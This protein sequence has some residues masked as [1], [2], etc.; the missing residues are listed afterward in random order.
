MT[1]RLIRLPDGSTIQEV[2]KWST[3]P[4]QNTKHREKWHQIVAEEQHLI[5]QPKLNLSFQHGLAADE[6]PE[7]EDEEQMLHGKDLP[8]GVQDQPDLNRL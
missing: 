4:V 1:A 8:N 2:L 7:E 6:M 3:F 5:D